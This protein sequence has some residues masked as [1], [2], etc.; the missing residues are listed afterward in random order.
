MSVLSTETLEQLSTSALHRMINEE[1]ERICN[2]LL[3]YQP[4][5]D[6]TLRFLLKDLQVMH[7][8][9]ERRGERLQS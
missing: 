7:K 1:W 8:E 4:V 5:S 3:R 2:V 6:E 9:L